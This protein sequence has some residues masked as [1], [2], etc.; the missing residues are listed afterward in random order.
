[1]CRV[2]SMPMIDEHEP[3]STTL[4]DHPI[5]EAGCVAHV[6]AH[7]IPSRQEPQRDSGHQAEPRA[8]VAGVK[9]APLPGV[10]SP[11][12]N[13]GRQPAIG[14]ELEEAAVAEVRQLIALERLGVRE[15]PVES[16]INTEFHVRTSG[17]FGDF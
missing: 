13:R 5:K 2:V 8:D 14:A 9:S 10:Q 1:M 12:D 4:T 7:A 11:R 17:G 3:E 15:E 6:K 16:E